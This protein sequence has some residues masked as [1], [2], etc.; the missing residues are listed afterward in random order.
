MKRI[1]FLLNLVI[2]SGINA[3]AD[4]SKDSLSS[5]VRAR[6]NQYADS[7]LNSLEYRTG[8]YT[9]GN[10]LATVT[11]PEGCFF[12]DPKDSRVLMEDLY[13]NPP[14]SD[15]LGVMLSG[16][17]SSEGDIDWVVEYAYSS[18]GHVK[19]DDAKD[20]NYDELLEQLKKTTIEASAERVKRGYSAMKLIGWAQKPF[21]DATNHKLHW[22]KEY[23]F[24]DSKQHTLNYD[25]RVLGRKGYLEMIIISGMDKLPVVNKNIDRILASTNFNDGMRYADFDSKVDKIA[26]YGIGGL[27]A[28]G[29]LAKTGIL[30]KIGIFLFKGLKIIVVGIIALFAALRN[31]FF[32][33]KKQAVAEPAAIAEST[34]ENAN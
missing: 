10:N 30:A 2:I 13:G 29:I 27:I 3:F 14:D 19:D 21:Y 31:K 20:Q 33:R 16:R 5:E 22:A 6:L 18:D 1:F 34:D 25:I 7:L 15:I 4:V 24:D 32:G 9:V 26:E 12:L 17:P 11:I 28:G 23:E 8:T